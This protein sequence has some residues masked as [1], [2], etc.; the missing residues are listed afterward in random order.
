MPMRTGEHNEPCDASA[1]GRGTYSCCGRMVR[2]G[3]VVVLARS[4][5]TMDR[6]IDGALP[7]VYDPCAYAIIAKNGE[8]I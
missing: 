2:I 7:I 3:I 5:A 8:A 4:A 1:G 6:D